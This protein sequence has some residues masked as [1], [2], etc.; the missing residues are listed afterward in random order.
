[1]RP[2]SREPGR[3]IKTATSR[4]RTRGVR[5]FLCGDIM[6]GRGLDQV[7][8]H[9][10]DPELRERHVGS[11]LTYVALAE[12]TNGPIT[13]PVR[14]DD[15]W[16]DALDE[17]RQMGPDARLANLET[18]IT[19]SNDFAPKGI[20]YRMAP[21]NA[22]CLL[23]A[24]LDA[25]SLAN[26]H[27]LDFG[28][29][30]LVETLDVLQ[31]LGLPAAGAGRNLAE[32]NAPVVIPLPG[33]SARVI[34]AAAAFA[35]SGVPP[36]WRAEPDTPGL[37]LLEPSDAAARQ[38]AARIAEV[39]RPRDIGVASI[40]WGSN[41]GYEVADAHRRFAHALIDSG[42]VSVVH[43]HSSHHPRPVEVY[44]DR[45][46]L[47][48]CGDFLND[49]EGIGGYETFRGDLVAMYFADLD[50]RGDLLGLELTP[51]AIRRFRLNRATAADA[52]WLGETL[53]RE[54]AR[55]G[56]SFRLVKSGR[57]VA[58]WSPAQ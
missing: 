21:E 4:N 20:N 12:R 58:D 15:I 45:L 53:G 13:R 8:A 55:F 16:G 9:P 50:S 11:A 24:G 22:P 29:S 43:G 42:E 54:S 1:M 36:D 48:G 35:D 28:R 41:W 25:C 26:N 39:R 18:A 27:A 52:Q 44:R 14:D 6:T 56:V 17:W 46:I 38:L 7:L 51:L 37:S 10:V 30:G 49:Y 34:F 5:L 3:G 40:H 47:Y 2:S 23:A 57:L 32:A 33:R 19:L 31:R